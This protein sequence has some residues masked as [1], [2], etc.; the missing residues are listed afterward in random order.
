MKAA[1]GNHSG[2]GFQL[3]DAA[4]ATVFN[5]VNRALRPMHY[6]SL[7]VDVDAIPEKYIDNSI[8]CVIIKYKSQ[9]RV[10]LLMNDLLPRA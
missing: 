7:A 3:W 1:F 8:K 5:D 10:I 4:C 9:G 2:S 6:F